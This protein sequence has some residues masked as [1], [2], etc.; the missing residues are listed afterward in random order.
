[1]F[2]FLHQIAS[3]FY[4]EYGDGISRMAFVF[5]N[6]RAGVFFK[7]YLSE[8]AGRPVFSPAILTMTDLFTEL[9]G[10]RQADRIGMLF[11]LYTIY[12]RISGST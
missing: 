11:S 3:L 1:M 6:Q 7:K 2:P 5:P 10:K 8:I 4:R 9:S 12:C